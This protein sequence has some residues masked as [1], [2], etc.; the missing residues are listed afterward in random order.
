MSVT[1]YKSLQDLR[2][3]KD[4]FYPNSNSEKTNLKIFEKIQNHTPESDKLIDNRQRAIQKVAAYKARGNIP[5]SIDAT[6]LL[7]ASILLDEKLTT[8]Q[9]S[10]DET[11][12]NLSYT[13]SIIKFVNGL[14]DPL[15]KS[16]FAMSLHKCAEILK[17]PSYFVEVRHM[18]THEFMLSLE[19]LRLAAKNALVWLEDNYWKEAIQEDKDSDADAE[20]EDLDINQGKLA[21]A[22]L[23]R[24]MKVVRSIRREDL[25]KFYKVGDSTE[26]GTK[27]WEAMDFIKGFD[28]QQLINF[29]ILNSCLVIKGN[30]TQKQINGIRLLYKPVLEHLGPEVVRDLF[31]AF[32][33]IVN[34]DQYAEYDADLDLMIMVGDAKLYIAKDESQVDQMES[35]LTYF[36]SNSLKFSNELHFVNLDTAEGIFKQLAKTVSGV[37]IRLM[38]CFLAENEQLLKNLKIAGKVGSLI[39]TMDKFYVAPSEKLPLRKRS[40][41]DVVDPV[42]KKAKIEEAPEQ[43]RLFLFEPYDDW[44]PTPFGVCIE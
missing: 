24:N 19:M 12:I 25:H 30:L 6:C 13:M 23:K 17:L 39:S 32:L 42:D 14:L 28:R 5:H 22:E 21:L 40:L 15:Q 29:L 34:R 26:Q 31:D 36:V 9:V 3:L 37:N 10:F 1:P 7:T 4:W 18:G 35:W 27:Y 41:D 8:G 43:A 38:R 2:Q 20:E 11:P 44:K 16:Q 33:E